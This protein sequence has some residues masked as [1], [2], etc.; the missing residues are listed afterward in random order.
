MTV[1]KFITNVTI[2]AG[3][4]LLVLGTAS[5]LAIVGSIDGPSYLGLAL[6]VAGY[7]YKGDDPK[8]KE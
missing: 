3:L 4:G 2:R 5:Y 8:Q 7:F 6:L 1:P